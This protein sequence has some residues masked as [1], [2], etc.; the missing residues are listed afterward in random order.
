LGMSHSGYDPLNRPD[1]LVVTYRKD[2]EPLSE[3]EVYPRPNVSLV[4]GA[5]GIHSTMADMLL[6]I[7]GWADGRVLDEAS[8]RWMQTPAHVSDLPLGD[9]YG[10]GCMIWDGQDS[11]LPLHVGHLG[12]IHGNL[13]L[14]FVY[15][16]QDLILVIYSNSY[17]ILRALLQPVRSVPLQNRLAEI[18]LEHVE[19]DGE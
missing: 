17:D 18:L 8:L 15:P 11:G 14:P 19:E 9:S 4:H 10:M 5:G 3:F 13:C 6:W 16:E 2:D 7:D 12:N 1:D